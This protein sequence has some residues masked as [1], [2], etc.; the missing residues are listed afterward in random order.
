[1]G[2]GGHGRK[3]LRALLIEAAQSILRS[4]DPAARWGKR[5]LARKGSLAL[6]AS[7][8]ARKLTVAVWYLMMGRWTEL[9][10]L[11]R[12]LQIKISKILSHALV[13]AMGNT[14]T[15]LRE[16]PAASLQKGRVYH[17]DPAITFSPSPA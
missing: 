2:I 6:A 11:G 15:D 8:V 12:P 5:L 3:D 16:A 10:E 17:L 4:K 13:E 7:A 14:R 9:Q 1:G